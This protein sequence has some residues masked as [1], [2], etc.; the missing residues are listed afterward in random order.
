MSVA[1]DLNLQVAIVALIKAAVPTLE[2]YDH[3]PTNPG[4]EFIRVDGFHIEDD[5][6]KNAERGRHSFIVHHFL[7]PV[8][9]NSGPRGMTKGKQTIATIHAALMA[10]R[11]LG[12]PLDFETM[13]AAPDPDG[14]SA[15]VWTRYSVIL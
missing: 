1:D 10:A 6:P 12:R 3:V 8:S 15:H 5:S 7:R 4:E 14:A 11:P 9:S 13:D 2:V